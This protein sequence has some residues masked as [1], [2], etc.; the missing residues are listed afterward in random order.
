ML[1]TE[2][3]SESVELAHTLIDSPGYGTAHAQLVKHNFWD[4]SKDPNK[5]RFVVHATAEVM[6]IETGYA[7]VYAMDMKEAKDLANAL[8]A[9]AFKWDS[10]YSER[11][12]IESISIGEVVL[13]ED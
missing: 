9:D 6:V 4:E 10:F 2:R 1:S 11:S 8:D 3:Y 5:I 12:G 7:E 13:G